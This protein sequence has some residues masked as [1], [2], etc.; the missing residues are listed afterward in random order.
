MVLIHGKAHMKKDIELNTN[1]LQIKT[2]LSE[3]YSRLIQ[4]KQYSKDQF[5]AEAI[6]ITKEF[7]KT[8]T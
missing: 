3:Y 4:L 8:I 6:F 1:N 5:Q 7:Q 2:F